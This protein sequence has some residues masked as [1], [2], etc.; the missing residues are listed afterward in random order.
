[1]KNLRSALSL[2]VAVL[3]LTAMSA[4]ADEKAGNA[5]AGKTVFTTYCVVCHGPEGKGDGP[6]AAGLNPKPANF[7]DP[8]RAKGMTEE[9]QI[10]V[11]TNGGPA[12][13]LS[14]LMAPFGQSLSAQQIRDVVAYIRKT[15]K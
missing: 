4:W 10:N 13:K 15:F 3:S 8:V 5:E 9:K 14:P 12:E 6:G 11:V 7:R 1:M 2:G